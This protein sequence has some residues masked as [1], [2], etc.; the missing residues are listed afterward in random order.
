MFIKITSKEEL[1]K[2]LENRGEYEEIVIHY[3]CEE[4]DDEQVTHKE[5]VTEEM[6]EQF[7]DKGYVMVC[8]ECTEC[9]SVTKFL[10]WEYIQGIETD[11]RL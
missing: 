1:I 10:D 8:L 3:N 2:T 7:K 11:E 6:I 4:C 9:G 5:E